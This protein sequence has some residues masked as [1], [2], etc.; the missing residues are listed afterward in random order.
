[1]EEIKGPLD[2]IAWRSPEHIAMLGGLRNDTVLDYFSFS[3][4]F[5]RSA[6]NQVLK[7]QTQYS[8]PQYQVGGL[9]PDKPDIYEQ[10]RQMQGIEFIVY[11]A[12]DPFWIIR[13][14][15][16]LSPN[17]TRL[18]STYFVINE[19]VFMAPSL[20]GILS[21][22]LLGA[23]KFM[24]NA[25]DEAQKLPSYSPS[26]GYSYVTDQSISA[27]EP[28]QA[29]PK[30]TRVGNLKS[31]MNTPMPGPASTNSTAT[32]TGQTTPSSQN[33][34]SQSSIN[35]LDQFKSTRY[36]ERALMFTN[37]NT[38]KYLDADESTNSNDQPHVPASRVSTPQ[39]NNNNLQVPKK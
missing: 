28:T 17:E 23:S 37:A 15:E 25:L 34:N 6:N 8:E 36:M 11:I 29:T 22:R 1:M 4:F 27:S 39:T 13:K 31:A 5:D 16:R 38:T 30:P 20:Y 14:Q 21:S 9:Q 2:E 26:Q 12:N 18:L 10:L 33:S 7:M 24:N 19:N 3:P 35:P 32:T